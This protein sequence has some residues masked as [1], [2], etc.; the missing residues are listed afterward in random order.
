[1]RRLVVIESPYHSETPN[2]GVRN[3]RYL[4]ACLRDSILRGESPFA[5]HGLYTRHGVLN[6][7]VPEERRLSIEAGLAW[8]RVEE[9]GHIVYQ[10]LGISRGMQAGIALARAH[11]KGTEFRE[12]G[13]NW[14]SLGHLDLQDYL[15]ETES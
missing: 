15:K 9:V 7:K 10:D 13:P 12:L 1:M 5:S 11:G 8:L 14:E 6:D 4:S 2:E 3:D